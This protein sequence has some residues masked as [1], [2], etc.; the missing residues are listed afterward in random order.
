MGIDEIRALPVANLAHAD[1]LWTTNAHMRE[2]FGVLEAWSF[3][4]K[5]I[6]TWLK[7]RIGTGDWLRGQ[8]EHC[9]LAVRGKPVVQL[10]NQTTVLQAPAGEHS[11]KPQAFYDLV[12]SLCPAPRYCERFQRRPRPNWDGH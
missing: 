8:T 3:Q 4:H 6:L 10:S 12:E 2:A 7:N 1:W 9:L 11:S 5:T